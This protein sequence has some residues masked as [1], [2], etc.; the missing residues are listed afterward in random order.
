MNDK[1]MKGLG[2]GA[3]VLGA[4]ATVVGNVVGQKQQDAKIQEAATKAVSDL[5][6]KE[7]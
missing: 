7:G 4:I 2:I 3:T 5:M 1:L 6:N